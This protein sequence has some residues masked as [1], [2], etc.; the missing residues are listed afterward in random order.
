MDTASYASG[1]DNE[2]KDVSLINE[3]FNKIFVYS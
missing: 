3:A 2:S 1:V